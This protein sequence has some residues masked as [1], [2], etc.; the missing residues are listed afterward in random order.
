M[1]MTMA[2]Y[3]WEDMCYGEYDISLECIYLVIQ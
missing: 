2:D 1:T 3:S